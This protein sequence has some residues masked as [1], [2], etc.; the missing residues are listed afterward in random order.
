M[1]AD[2]LRRFRSALSS[3]A[4]ADEIVAIAQ[5]LRPKGLGFNAIGSLKTAPR[6]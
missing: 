5:K 3:D 1:A 4:L 2:Q 6:D